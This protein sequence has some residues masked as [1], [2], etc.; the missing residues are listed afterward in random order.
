VYEL[1]ANRALTFDF[2]RREGEL[3]ATYLFVVSEG[4]PIPLRFV[5]RI[6]DGEG[7][8]ETGRFLRRLTRMQGFVTGRTGSRGR[9]LLWEAGPR[10]EAQPGWPDRIGRLRIALGDDL[11][12][13]RHQLRLRLEPQA[14][15]APPSPLW[16]R[17]VL[18]GRALEH[19]KQG[20][21]P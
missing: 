12:V 3:L 17:G 8:A 7:S 2:E 9:G 19:A 20:D 1:T 11:A 15:T 16:V 6:D 13:G 4:S 10:R 18:V 5:Y 14:R 21:Q